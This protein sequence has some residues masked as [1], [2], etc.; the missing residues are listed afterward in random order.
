MQKKK[1]SR[2]EQETQ[3]WPQYT[4]IYNLNQMQLNDQHRRHKSTASWAA[5]GRGYGCGCEC[6]LW[7][8]EALS[9]M[10]RV[11]NIQYFSSCRGSHS[12]N[13][14]WGH[15]RRRP[16]AICYQIK[17]LQATTGM[18]SERGRRRGRRGDGGRKRN[19]LHKFIRTL[20]N[21]HILGE[22]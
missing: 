10:C 5:D 6:G 11:R 7:A 16:N 22:G 17:M 15:E 2:G 20:T 8:V 1:T 4:T 18:G 19:V 21:E 13:A 9:T 3:T 14:I 12:P